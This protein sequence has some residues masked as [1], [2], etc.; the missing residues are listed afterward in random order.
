MTSEASLAA[1]TSGAAYIAPAG[2]PT[3]PLSF[4]ARIEFSEWFE[5][6]R[7]CVFLDG[8]PLFGV[9]G[10]SDHREATGQQFDWATRI[11]PGAHA[12]TMIVHIDQAQEPDGSPG[13]GHGTIVGSQAFE[14]AKDEG[15]TVVG[16]GHERAGPGSREAR[17]VLSWSV[18][19]TPRAS[20]GEPRDARFR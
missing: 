8:A 3:I 17:A 14:A 19:R 13:A 11:V 16:T 12:V 9:V 15:V 18:T 5:L 1:C 7:V 10:D 2:V 4:R 20:A 6:D